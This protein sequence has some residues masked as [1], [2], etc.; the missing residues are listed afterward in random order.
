VL[1]Y[2]QSAVRDISAHVRRV[3]EEAASHAYVR[4]KQLSLI[5]NQ[6]TSNQ[7]FQRTSAPSLSCIIGS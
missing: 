3:F 4:S 1:I 5:N 6:R 2:T 7:A